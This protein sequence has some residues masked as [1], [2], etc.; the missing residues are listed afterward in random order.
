MND[1]YLS[2]KEQLKNGYYPLVVKTPR[3]IVE[4]SSPSP[5]DLDQSGRLSYAEPEFYDIYLLSLTLRSINGRVLPRD[6]DLV[7]SVLSGISTSMRRRMFVYTMCL[8]EESRKAYDLLEAFCYEEE[9]RLLW[10]SWKASQRF[11]ISPLSD[12][13]AL[14]P[15]QSNWIIWNTAEDDRILDRSEWDRFLFSASAMN[16]NVSKIRTKW[17]NSEKE[18]ESRRESMRRAARSGDLDFLKDDKRRNS[19]N[20]VKT[21]DDLREEMRRWVA[22]EEDGHDKIIREYKE[23]MRRNIRETEERAQRMAEEARQ[24]RADMIDVK[25]TPI[26]ALTDEQVNRL[27]NVKRTVVT[28]E[29]GEKN[30]HVISKYIIGEESRGNL[31]INEDG[32]ISSKDQA[33]NL[34]NDLSRRVPKLEEV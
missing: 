19:S 29:H 20:G 27:S 33:R 5:E 1:P 2:V 8:L 30:N 10:R 31:S 4:M 9:S 15:L 6:A 7:M 12:Q 26:V 18:E 32:E 22:G 34:M 3:V 17:D 13:R 16:S 23:S 24:R 28:D 25:S 14:S 11:G 21:E